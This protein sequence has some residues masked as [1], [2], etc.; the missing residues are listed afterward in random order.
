MKLLRNI[1][2]AAAVAAVIAAAVKAQREEEIWL[3]LPLAEFDLRPGPWYQCYLIDWML[4]H[5]VTN[6]DAATSGIAKGAESGEF[7]WATATPEWDLGWFN[8]HGWKFPEKW[9]PFEYLDYATGEPGGPCEI[10]GL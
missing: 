1:L 3:D 4:A 6:P 7:I 9:I 10:E 8:S 5:N 2:A